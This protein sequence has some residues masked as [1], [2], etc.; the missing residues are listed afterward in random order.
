MTHL[1]R[2]LEQT[3]P[4]PKLTGDND[5]DEESDM[6]G[7]DP[8]L[9]SSRGRLPGRRRNGRRNGLR[10]RRRETIDAEVL[11][12]E[13]LLR[14]GLLNLRPPPGRFQCSDPTRDINWSSSFFGWPCLYGR[15]PSALAIPTMAPSAIFSPRPVLI[16]QGTAFTRFITIPHFCRVSGGL[17][18]YSFP[19]TRYRT[20]PILI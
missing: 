6:G 7:E 14:R 11:T 5:P 1:W 3:F 19:S 2:Y 12:G 4:D 8:S 17:L 9:E 10:N 16:R 13:G 20:R 18:N 15:L